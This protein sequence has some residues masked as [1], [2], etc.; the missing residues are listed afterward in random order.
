[1]AMR[2]RFGWVGVAA[3]MLI[4]VSACGS[5][6]GDSDATT[7]TAA[8]ETT[9]TAAAV[10]TTSSEAT[11][12]TAAPGNDAAA[13]FDDLPDRWV[14]SAV[15]LDQPGTSFEYGVEVDFQADPQVGD[16][17]AEVVYP[18][19]GCSGTWTLSSANGAVVT[20]EETITDDPRA[21][22]IPVTTVT[23]ERE[24][25]TSMHYLS[26]CGGASANCTATATLRPA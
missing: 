3:L 18:E 9:T 19:L 20:A 10:T 24:S 26:E 14:A 17:L 16:T 22:C 8:P 7:T 23:L 2:R 13:F 1:M 11:T 6:G 25:D 21:T 5:G 15:E 12:T 4:A